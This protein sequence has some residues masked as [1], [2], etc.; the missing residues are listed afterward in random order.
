MILQATESIVWVGIGV[1]IFVLVVFIG[2]VFGW[3][4]YRNTKGLDSKGRQVG[5]YVATVSSPSLSTI[6]ACPV[7]YYGS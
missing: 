7:L 2:G 1:G 4:Y 5:N 3:R 6:V